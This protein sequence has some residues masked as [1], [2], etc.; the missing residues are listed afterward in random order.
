M[1]HKVVWQHMKCVVEF[2]LTSLLQIYQEILEWI[3]FFKSVKI[4]QNYGHEFVAS[5]FWSTLYAKHKMPPIIVDVP[6]FLCMFVCLLDA[7]VN[8]AKEAEPIEMP[9]GRVLVGSKEPHFRWKFWSCPLEGAFSGSGFAWAPDLPGVDIRSLFTRA[10]NFYSA[11]NCMCCSIPLTK[12]LPIQSQRWTLVIFSSPNP[13][14]PTGLQTQRN[15]TH[16][17]STCIHPAHPLHSRAN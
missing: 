6:W 16:L 7:T 17:A 10:G 12:L 13:T 15:P 2:V 8:P 4:W 1:F 11:A 14:R 5:L 9:F 3:F